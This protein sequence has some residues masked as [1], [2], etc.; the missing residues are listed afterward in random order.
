M[1]RVRKNRPPPPYPMPPSLREEVVCNM[2]GHVATSYCPHASR[3]VVRRDTSI[4]SCELFDHLE[5]IACAGDRNGECSFVIDES[6]DEETPVQR[7]D[8]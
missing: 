4:P 5:G 1:H 8:H 2:S 3:V 6:H 7:D